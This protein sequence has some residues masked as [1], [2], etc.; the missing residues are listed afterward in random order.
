MNYCRKI[1]PIKYC[2]FKIYYNEYVNKGQIGYLSC[3][4]SYHSR[5]FYSNAIIIADIP[6]KYKKCE[7]DLEL[8]TGEIESYPYKIKGKTKTKIF[9]KMIKKHLK[10]VDCPY[11]FEREVYEI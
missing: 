4:D 6:E 9:W 5:D 1:C 8:K 3:G 2:L 7:F 11:K 10:T